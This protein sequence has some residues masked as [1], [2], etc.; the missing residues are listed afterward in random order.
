[1]LYS[2][3]ADG[4]SFRFDQGPSFYLMNEVF[5][6]QFT[7]LGESREDWYT[8]VKCDPNYLVHYHDGEV[9]TLSTDMV[10]MKKEIEKWEGKD[11]WI[12]FMNFMSESHIHY[13]VSLKE[14]L[15][16]NFPNIRS[17]L[18]LPYVFMVE[19]LHVFNGLYRQA[20]NYFYSDRLRRAFTFSSMYLGMSP[21][22]A[23]ATYNLLQY[24]ELAQGIW[25]PI[26]GFNKVVDSYEK[27]ARKK[28]GAEFRYNSPVTSISQ[29][30]DGK[31]ATG[32]T[33][34]TGEHIEADVVISNADL[35]WTYENLLPSTK[36][37]K[38]ICKNSKLTCSSISFYW[39]MK[40]KVD[41]LTTHNIFLG[42]EYAGS[43]DKIFDEHSLPDEAS[44]YVNVP[45]RSDPTAAPE[46]KD[47]FVVLVPCGH[48]LGANKN[49]NEQTN[50]HAL[51]GR[52]APDQQ[53]GHP[54]INGNGHADPK[55][56]VEKSNGDVIETQDWNA[57]IARA[58]AEVV[59]KLT[60]KFGAAAGLAPGESF[61]SLIETEMVNTPQTW[62][63]NLNLYKG[64]ILGL[65]HNILQVM[66]LRPR[67]T[68]DTIKS[69]YFVGASTHPGTGVPVVVC[70]A[71]LTS[72]QVLNDLKMDIPWKLA[73]EAADAPV[74]RSQPLNQ[75]TRP[76]P[77]FQ[78][79]IA[80]LFLLP[81][82]IA[83]FLIRLVFRYDTARYFE[84]YEK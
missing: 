32:V 77:S 25:Y 79:K 65:S 50:G 11:G 43:F 17:L 22:N 66:C 34:A 5:E 3:D 81:I 28:F 35:L 48:L 45:S 4:K 41:A 70:G 64:S 74:N 56:K 7:D 31:H 18:S 46:G 82:V 59:T 19:K 58:R 24:T 21:Y 1:L 15:H 72:E 36:Y 60:E 20:S 13:E 51:D 80:N 61:E 40:R 8:L 76:V 47:T 6:E 62:R 73:G 37:Q 67:L 14:V 84:R 69:L 63:D 44:F 53:N 78:E 83:L 26:G 33:L 52:S 2:K 27:I 54:H 38:A 30:A 10:K 39:G 9:V 49:V 68:H 29:S 57:I 16:A 23:P 71:K 55:M 75:L 12:R 42:E